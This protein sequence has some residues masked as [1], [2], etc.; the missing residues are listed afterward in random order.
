VHYIVGNSKFYQVLLPT[1]RIF[2]ALFEAAG[3]EAVHVE[4]IRKRTSKREL[5]EFL[6]SARKP[7]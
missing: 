5:F 4:T 6:V 7:T 3:F 1:E 2:A